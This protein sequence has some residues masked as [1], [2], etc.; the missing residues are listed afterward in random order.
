MELILI[1][2]GAV[3]LVGGGWALKNYL[4]D[5]PKRQ[6]EETMAEEL[7]E[8]H[9]EAVTFGNTGVG[10]TFARSFRPA[11]PPP[12]PAQSTRYD[13]TYE[14]ERKRKEEEER[15]R[16]YDQND[17]FL[18]GSGIQ[19]SP[20]FGSRINLAVDDVTAS[21]FSGSTGSGFT[22]STPRVEAEYE[23]SS[24]PS[25]ED[26][27]RSYSPSTSTYNDDSSS[28]SSSSSDSS[29]YDSSSSSSSDSSSSSSDSSSS[30][31]SD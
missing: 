1:G 13:N 18:P 22:E 16:R 12:P 31:S 24:Q 23:R 15:R 3:G 17:D 5:V 2:L 9:S 20:D 10:S 25:I 26:D 14:N 19:L 29:S 11:P 21:T 4:F 6:A 7:E 27:G 28:R 8:N 30:S